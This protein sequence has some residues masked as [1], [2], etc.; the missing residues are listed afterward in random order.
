[1]KSLA[2]SDLASPF[3]YSC[4]YSWITPQ[5]TPQE[6]A[7]RISE[8][9]AQLARSAQELK[10]QL[11]HRSRQDSIRRRDAVKPPSGRSCSVDRGYLTK[12]SL[13]TTGASYSQQPGYDVL[14]NRPNSAAQRARQ[15]YFGSGN[16]TSHQIPVRLIE[17]Q[18]NY[19]GHIGSP[20]N[21]HHSHTIDPI[22]TRS[23]I[24]ERIE[25][26]YGPGALA[27]GFIRRSPGP[28]YTSMGNTVKRTPTTRTEGRVIPIQLEYDSKNESDGLPSVFRHLRPEFRHQLPVKSPVGPGKSIPVKREDSKD[29]LGPTSPTS[30]GVKSPSAAGVVLPPLRT[31][32]PPL[33]STDQFSPNGSADVNSSSVKYS[34]IDNKS[35]KKCPVL[36]DNNCDPVVKLNGSTISVWDSLPEV[37]ARVVPDE[38]SDASDPLNGCSKPSVASQDAPVKDGHYFLKVRQ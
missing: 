26:L 10:G 19:N 32:G 9:K 1:M 13:I 27:A 8:L 3:V 6:T 29:S 36:G 25:R 38:R 35:S 33:T 2:P 20:L 16:M 5:S 30:N 22:D 34:H 18:P 15:G 12:A 37:T 28:S 14:D 31:P 21:L 7:L 17:A 11:D 23:F 4:P 24:Q